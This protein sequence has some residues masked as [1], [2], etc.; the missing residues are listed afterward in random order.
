MTE[1]DDLLAGLRAPQKTISPKY[2][3]DERGSQLFEEITDQPEYYP[4]QT[5]LGIL[6]ANVA[7]IGAAIGSSVSLIEFGAGASVKVRVL[8]DALPQIHVFVPVDI[9]ADHLR[10]AT[11]ELKHDYPGTEIL[12][13]G[14]D[15]TRPF[16]LPAPKRIPARNIVFFPGSTIGNFPP[17][18]ATA[19][20]ETMRAVAKPGGGLLIGV[21]L[22]KDPDVLERAY[23]DAAGVTAAFNLNMLRHLNTK[24]EADFNV[25]D[26]SHRA[27]Y[28]SQ[29][30]RIEMHLVSNKAQEFTLGGATFAMASGEYLLTE[31]SYKYSI[32]A[33][34]ELA[35]GAGFNVKKVW[36]DSKQYFS[37]QYCEVVC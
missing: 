36:T 27:I 7:E 32:S 35:A 28:N 19:L 8:L 17:D 34:S 23:N 16:G 20:L 37:L 22:R 10:D 33:F 14:A 5:E 1:L 31:C 2:F 6:K 21:D 12:P 4:T 3:Y 9:S 15:F 18:V 25:D 11:A 13:V 30:N 29:A 26:F 24:F